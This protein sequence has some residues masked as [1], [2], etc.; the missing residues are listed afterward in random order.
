MFGNYNKTLQRLS[1]KPP[2]TQN[3]G[4]TGIDKKN[5]GRNTKIVNNVL[6]FF[7]P[8]SE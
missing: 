6:D 8:I 4:Q 7:E 3:S 2:A 5:A 1:W